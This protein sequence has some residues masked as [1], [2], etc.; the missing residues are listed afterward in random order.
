MLDCARPVALDSTTGYGEWIKAKLEGLLRLFAGNYEPLPLRSWT[1]PQP[2]M[3]EPMPRH[4]R[5]DWK[6]SSDRKQ[7]LKEHGLTLCFA[8]A[9]PLRKLNSPHLHP[10]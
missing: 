5:Y 3:R 10:P 1:P 6:R 9:G 7:H 2:D 4:S 8:W